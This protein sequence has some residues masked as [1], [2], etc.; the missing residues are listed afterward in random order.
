[1]YVFF[2]YCGFLPQSKKYGVDLCGTSKYPVV[3]VY[4]V[5][6]ESV[7]LQGMLGFDVK[8]M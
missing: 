5:G 7:M 2:R 8:W 3:F 4:I 6:V 1:M